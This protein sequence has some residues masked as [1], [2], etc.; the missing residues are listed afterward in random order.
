MML[1]LAMA[2]A[3]YVATIQNAAA[4]AARSAFSNCVREAAAQA[5]KDNV[6][7]EGLAPQVRQAC[8]AQGS[9][10]KAALVA[11]DVKNG[12]KR[13]Q[14]AEDADLQLEDYYAAQ[15][16]RYEYEIEAKKPKQAVAAK[17]EQPA[18]SN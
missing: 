16:E 7:L 8:E 11:F 12:V 5:K 17:A 6:P 10:L 2:S 1:T 3:I 9:K 15:Q 13:S 14:A 18:T 4:S